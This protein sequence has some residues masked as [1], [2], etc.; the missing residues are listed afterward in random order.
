MIWLGF[1]IGQ[2]TAADC[3][4]ADSDRRKDRCRFNGV[5]WRFWRSVQVRGNGIRRLPGLPI[6]SGP[7]L[8]ALNPPAARALGAYDGPNSDAASASASG[9][10][11]WHSHIEHTVPGLMIIVTTSTK[12]TIISTE[13]PDDAGDDAAN[14]T[15]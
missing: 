9:H 2:A 1:T 8:Q 14:L 3:S 7:R 13:S 4:A 6:A 5:L 10:H 11:N 15:K 12:T